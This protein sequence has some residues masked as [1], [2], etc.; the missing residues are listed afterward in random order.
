MATFALLALT[1]LSCVKYG[2][3][4]RYAAFCDI[5]LTW[6]ACSQVLTLSKR[7]STTRPA[8]VAASLFLVLS[9]IGL[10]QYERIFVRGGLYDPITS[11][12]VMKLD[13]YKSNTAV[14]AE[15]AAPD[16]R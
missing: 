7:L 9:V 1:A 8:I 6:L 12:L 4:L 3:S 2:I 5:P 10:N 16:H 13:M 15:L 11:Q 14:R